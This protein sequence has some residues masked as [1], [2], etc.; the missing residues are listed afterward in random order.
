[1]SLWKVRTLWT[2]GPGGQLVS[3]MYFDTSGGTAAQAVTA[4]G[5]FW[6]AIKA[7]I[8]DDLSFATDPNVFEIDEA[9]GQ[10][11]GLQA[12]T[13]VTAGCTQSGDPLPF[14]T[15]GVLQWRTGQFI[16]GR[17]IRGRT[18][19]PGMSET[20]ATGG[21]PLAALQT[22]INTAAAA[23]IADG[24]SDLQVYSLKYHNAQSVV[25]GTMWSQF[26]VLRS[27]RL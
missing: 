11:I 10:P 9:T 19:I 26:G 2:G 20:N 12:T 16:N 22:T 1:M 4:V 24:N 13:P 17:E 5:T 23:L 8:V 27:R 25:S 18:F 15:Q 3:T 7:S 14:M 6:N 21:V